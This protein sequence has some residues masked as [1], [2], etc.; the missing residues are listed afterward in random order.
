MDD[1]ELIDGSTRHRSPVGVLFGSMIS[2]EDIAGDV[3]M[4]EL[5]RKTCDVIVVAGGMFW[6]SVERVRGRY[7]FARSMRAVEFG[8]A[9]NMIMRGSTLVWHEQLPSWLSNPFDKGDP[10]DL[11]TKHVRRMVSQFRGVIAYWDVLNEI[12]NVRDARSDG[13]RQSQWL[14]HCGVAYI[15][16][17]LRAAREADPFARLGYNE[18]G[19]EDDSAEADQKRSAVLALMRALR[20]RGVPIDYLGVQ[21]HLHGKQTFSSAKLGKFLRAVEDLGLLVLVTE[22]DVD[23]RVF[24]SDITNRDIGV[25]EIYARF[26][27][28]VLRN[29]APAMVTVWGLS[30]RQSFPQSTRP[31]SDGLRQRSLPFDEWL[32]PKPAWKALV[33]AGV[34]RR[35]AL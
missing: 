14:Q 8:R 33:D 10:C 11:L 31:R 35:G 2:P 29:A 16:S 22:L 28:I 27:D 5:A 7:E 34:A 3:Q 1:S 17:A 24:S 12:V 18:W 25:A 30:D 32:R 4:R 20:T 13:L 19:L 21:A 23:D 9:N 6:A 26:L 15:E